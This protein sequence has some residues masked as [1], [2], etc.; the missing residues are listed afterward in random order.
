M[1]SW[2]KCLFRS[3]HVSIGLFAFLTQSCVSCLYVLEMNL[4][5]SLFA[6]TFPHSE[7]CLFLL[8][9]LAHPD[10]LGYGRG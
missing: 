9:A 2:E 3:A 10:E 6:D 7:G 4:L 8:F 1:S 5:S